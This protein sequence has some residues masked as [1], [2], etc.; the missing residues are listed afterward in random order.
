LIGKANKAHNSDVDDSHASPDVASIQLPIREELDSLSP[1]EASNHFQKLLEIQKQLSAQQ[2]ELQQ[3]LSDVRLKMNKA[4]Q[5]PTME[6]AKTVQ[7]DVTGGAE[8]VTQTGS[9]Q[10]LRVLELPA[11]PPSGDSSTLTVC[12]Q[13]KGTVNPNMYH[14]FNYY[15]RKMTPKAERNTSTKIMCLAWLSS[16]V[17][18]VNV[19][20]ETHCHD[21]EKMDALDMNK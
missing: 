11:S 17:C 19:I 10:V 14:T 5:V 12:C 6:S 2:A 16:A 4:Q 13:T 18:H 20:D 8:V 15:V 9:Q 3:Q 7:T 21:K 1:E